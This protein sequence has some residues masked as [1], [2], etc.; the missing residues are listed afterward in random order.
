MARRVRVHARG[1]AGLARSPDSLSR[2]LGADFRHRFSWYPLE[3]VGYSRAPLGDLAA[4]AGWNR[5]TAQ[6]RATTRYHAGWHGMERGDRAI[7]AASKRRR[8]Q[9]RAGR[10]CERSRSVLGHC[11][12]ALAEFRIWVRA[13]LVTHDA[14]DQGGSMTRSQ[15]ASRTESGFTLVELLVSLSLLVIMLTLINGSLQFGRRAWEVS[16]QVERIDS[17][18]AFRNLLG[19]MLVETLPLVSS[20]DRGVLTSA[21]QG[22]S[23]QISFASPMASRDGRPAGVFSVS[24]K[25]APDAGSA[26]RPLSLELKPSVAANVSAGRDAHAPVVVTNVS[27]L[28]ISYY[29]APERG[30]EPRWFDDW[31]GRSTLPTMVSVDVQFPTG[32]PRAWVPFIA[33]LKLGSRARSERPPP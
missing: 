27:R 20:D 32:D 16:D 8:C 28:A 1:D 15:I 3:R 7:R 26:A 5:V 9:K 24:L 2:R 14:E 4:C 19:Q 33:E 10:R 13:R 21:F 25:L 6:N 22:G 30:G 31:R 29:G 17:V 11:R 12:G 23:D 18:V